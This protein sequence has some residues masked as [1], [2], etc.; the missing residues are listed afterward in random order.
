M[1]LFAVLMLLASALMIKGYRHQQLA[2]QS[3]YATVKLALYGIGVGLITG[4]LGAGG[5]FLIMPAL[6][7]LARL[8]PKEAIGTSLFITAV[9]SL[10]GFA[11]DIG[12]VDFNWL[13]VSKLLA[14][15]ILGVFLGGAIGRKIPG[16]KLRVGFGWFL[17]TAGIGILVTE[18][19]HYF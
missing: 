4:I 19:L 12:H 2:Q 15:T 10:V 13:F 11:G 8:P 7:I 6:I 16:E 9:N 1:I 5:G 17:F 3:P 18:V 14:V